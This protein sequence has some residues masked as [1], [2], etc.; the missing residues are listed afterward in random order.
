MSLEN[1]SSSAAFDLPN[2]SRVVTRSRDN[3]LAVG[4]EFHTVDYIPMAFEDC[5]GVVLSAIPHSRGPVIRSCC[6][7]VAILTE[8]GVQDAV[9]MAIQN[10]NAGSVFFVPHP[11]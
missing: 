5:D 10:R 11:G 7:S 8:G 9:C 3:P 2:T 1:D 4:A 6:N